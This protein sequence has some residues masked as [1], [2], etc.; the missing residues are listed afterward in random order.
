MFDVA[1]A[2]Y[3]ILMGWAEIF[4]RRLPCWALLAGKK[5]PR[6]HIVGDGSRDTRTRAEAAKRS[7]QVI[8]RL[9][10][11]QGF[12]AEHASEAVTLISSSPW[13]EEQ[14]TQ[15][16]T[17]VSDALLDTNPSP[18]RRPGQVVKSFAGFFSEKDIAILAGMA[19]LAVKIDCILQCERN[20]FCGQKY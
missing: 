16:T 6:E 7:G 14:K 2:R 5:T 12:T 20:C 1:C 13:P 9:Q 19:S 11:G 15:L 10:R 17:A 3:N 18:K 8:N 4:A